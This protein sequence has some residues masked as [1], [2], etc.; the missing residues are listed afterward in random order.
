MPWVLK[1]NDRVERRN[2]YGQVAA[3]IVQRAVDALSR[4]EERI[5]VRSDR[6]KIAAIVVPATQTKAPYVRLA[7]IITVD[8]PLVQCVVALGA[9]PVGEDL[10]MVGGAIPLVWDGLTT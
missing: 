5:V 4:G 8:D 2:P 6:H 10:L 1:Q 9:S 3:N 7:R